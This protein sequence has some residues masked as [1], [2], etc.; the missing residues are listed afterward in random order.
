MIAV[1]LSCSKPQYLH[2][3]FGGFHQ[4]FKAL[5]KMKTQFKTKIDILTFILEGMYQAEKRLQD[6]LPEAIE[7]ISSLSL[8][9]EVRKYVERIPDKRLKLKR[10]FSYL[11]AGRFDRKN[12][13]VD[14]MIEELKTNLQKS[15]DYEL[16]SLVAFINL[17]SILQYKISEYYVAKSIAIELDLDNVPELLAEILDWEK[18]TERAISLSLKNVNSKKVIM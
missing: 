2:H 9:N 7:L 18:E 12:K 15:A 1:I 4:P 14:E 5:K 11:L 17:K 6:E 8:K 13:I 3:S 10:I 16:N